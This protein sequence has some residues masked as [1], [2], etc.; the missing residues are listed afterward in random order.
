M[1]S[2]GI[3]DISVYVNTMVYD[4]GGPKKCFVVP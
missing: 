4:K 2:F 3:F 1:V